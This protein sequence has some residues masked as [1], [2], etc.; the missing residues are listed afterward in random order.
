MEGNGAKK[1]RFTLFSGK[2]QKSAFFDVFGVFGGGTEKLV[3]GGSDPPFWGSKTPFLSINLSILF[4][5]LSWFLLEKG[6]PP[7]YSTLCLGFSW[8][9]R[10]FWDPPLFFQRFS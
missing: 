8:K 4:H 3:F 7:F 10:H 1:D 6:T 5:T 2:V 9:K